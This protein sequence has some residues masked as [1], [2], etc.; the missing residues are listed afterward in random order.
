MISIS[1]GS[2]RSFILS[3]SL[4]SLQ[5]N[6]SLQEQAYQALR[7][8]ILSGELTS[9]TR[10]IETHLAKK[11]QVSRTP[12]REALRQLQNEDLVVVDGD[13]VLRVATFSQADA[14]Q[15][16]NCRMALEHQS[17]IEACENATEEQFY[18]LGLMVAQAEK[19]AEE[20]ASQLTNFQL[21]DL[22]YRFHRLLAESSGNLWLRSLLDQVFDKM[23]LLRIQTMQH[24]P[25][26]LNI[27]VEHRLIYEAIAQRD[28][29]AATQA[30]RNHLAAA[31]ERVILEMSHLHSDAHLMSV[32][33]DSILTQ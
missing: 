23:M 2:H 12:I 1:P 31:K 19:L 29:N 13:G 16:Y 27:R 10:L 4:R 25:N 17:A 30:I 28:V 8:A 11:L 21:L 33:D 22:D 26:V 5:R 14:I 24:N 20:K 7:T 18:G 15:L 3:L 6:Q 32:E 9:G